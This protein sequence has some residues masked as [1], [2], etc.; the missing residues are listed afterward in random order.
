MVAVPL[1][2]NLTVA[3]PSVRMTTR[4]IS[5]TGIALS[6]ARFSDVPYFVIDFTE[7]RL[8]LLQVLMKVLRVSS[9]GPMYEVAGKFI[10]RLRCPDW[11]N[12]QT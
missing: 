3:R 1:R 8:E 11:H 2:A 7:A 5:K 9:S 6:H 4:D 10:S 12:Q